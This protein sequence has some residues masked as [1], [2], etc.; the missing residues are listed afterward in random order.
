MSDL[1]KG[2]AAR[3]PSRTKQDTPIEAAA[4]RATTLANLAELA[5]MAALYPALTPLDHETLVARFDD[6]YCEALGTTTKA[7]GTLKDALAWLRMLHPP[8]GARSLGD[9]GVSA[10][11][12]ALFIEWTRR[13]QVEVESIAEG[14]PAGLAE[15]ASMREA[16][17]ARYRTVRDAVDEALGHNAKWI[18][19]LRSHLDS[20]KHGELDVD[21]ARLMRLASGVKAL[22][23]HHATTKHALANEGVTDATVQV[24]NDDALALEKA[25]KA[26]PRG[27]AV[28]RDTPA[29]NLVEGRVLVLMTQVFRAV[30]KA[31][32]A[33][34]TTLVLRP[35]AAT[36]RVIQPRGPRKSA[37]AEDNTD[38][39]APADGAA[40]KR[41][42]KARKR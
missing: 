13:L 38:G 12:K 30:N 18:T 27:G 31:R 36:K 10:T 6:A 8:A 5:R 15:E 21:V 1:S 34:R 35:G 40:K 37:E 3:T 16:A 23:A 42:T 26:R 11:V 17:K 19:V 25:A 29:T 14:L 33:K 9:T 32:A 22:L 41:S 7:R 39:V 20:E 24:C 2:K 4:M 28:D